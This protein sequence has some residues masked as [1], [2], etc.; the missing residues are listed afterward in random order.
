DRFRLKRYYATLEYQHIFS[1]QTE[2]DIKAFGGY[3]SRFSKRQ[4]GGGVGTLPIGAA[5]NTN[6]IQLR[7]VWNEGAEL[8][9]RHD[10]ALGGYTWTFTGVA[11]LYYALQDRD[12]QRGVTPDADSGVVR[13]L[14]D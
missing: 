4:R 10:Y 11:Y 3:L 13:N 8:R 2:L 1:E 9:L 5:A 14:A 6:S 7:E 12:D